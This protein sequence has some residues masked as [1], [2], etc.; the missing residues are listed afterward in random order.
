MG[1]GFIETGICKLSFE[2]TAM[3]RKYLIFLPALLVFG[4]TTAQTLAETANNFLNSLSPEQHRNTQMEF[5]DGERFDWHYVP[6]ERKGTTF[7]DFNKEQYDAALALL[8]QSLHE[9]GFEKVRAVMEL[10]KVLVLLENNRLKMPDGSPMRDPL[11][12]HFL[13][14]GDPSD[15]QPWG[16][17]FEGHHISLNFTSADGLMVSATPTFFGAN[18]GKVPSGDMKGLEVLKKESELGFALVNSLNPTQ[19]AK[20]VF[21]DTAPSEILTR[22]A[23]VARMPEHKGLAYSEMEAAQQKLFMELLEVYI[24]KYIFEFSAPFREK[25]KKAG[26]DNLHFAWA[27]SLLPGKGHY[28][29]IQGPMLLIEFDNTQN[30]ANHIHTVVRDL[31]NDFAGD[32]LES[33]YKEHH[34]KEKE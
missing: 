17:R 27:G 13:I 2:L 23:P 21:S 34:Q 28:Y 11:R 20:A 1:P 12:Y 32:L 29:S 31:T 14:F 25:I 15:A 9:N 7:H 19:L 30:Q 16:W 4:Y 33:H 24:G 8:R 5:M 10:E 3:Y 6:I 26:F 22:N 18:P